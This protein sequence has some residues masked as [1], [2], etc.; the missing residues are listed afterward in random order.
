MGKRKQVRKQQFI[1]INFELLNDVKPGAGDKICK[2]FKEKW[3]N[4]KPLCKK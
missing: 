1:Y 2:L 3:G 4:E